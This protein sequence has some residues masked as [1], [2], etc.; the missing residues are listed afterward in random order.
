MLVKV[1]KENYTVDFREYGKITVPHGTMTCHKAAMGDDPDYH[2]VSEFSWIDRDYPAIA[3]V[4]KPDMEQYGIKVCDNLLIPALRVRFIYDDSGSCRDIFIDRYSSKKYCRMESNGKRICW[5]TVTPDWEEPDCPLSTDIL[6]QIL[7]RN[8]KVAVTEQQKKENGDYFAEKRCLFSWENPHEDE[9]GEC[10][11]AIYRNE[12]FKY[13]IDGKKEFRGVVENEIREDGIVC[14]TDNLN[15]EE[16]KR[17]VNNPDLIVIDQKQ[18]D[19][20]IYK[21]KRSRMKVFEEIT[22]EEFYDKYEC[23][24]PRRIKKKDGAFSFFMGGGALEL[25]LQNFYFKYK[26]KYYYGIRDLEEKEDYLDHQVKAFITYYLLPY[27]MLLDLTVEYMDIHRD[28]G[29][30]SELDYSI[31]DISRAMVHS[32]YKKHG[33]CFLGKINLYDEDRKNLRVE[34]VPYEG[35]LIY[36]FEYSFILPCYDE[37]I[38]GLIREHNTKNSQEIMDRIVQIIKRIYD[39][40]GTSLVWS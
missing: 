37:K 33:Q 32:F 40:Q 14:Y 35:Q 16:Y 23:L 27:E 29:G 36:N 22:E 15:F 30:T 10:S 25:T 11:I 12:I 6:I 31:N 20:M 18:L 7:G 21:Y 34:L 28:T 9:L 17:S 13:I 3:A 24:P 39:L 38:I 5:Y 4:L 26:G 2:Q 8:G 19:D 1:L